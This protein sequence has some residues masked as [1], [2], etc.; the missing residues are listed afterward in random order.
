MKK[1]L[2]M[3]M[4]MALT[5][6]VLT[7]CGNTT[8]VQ[9]GGGEQAASE[10]EETAQAAETEAGNEAVS[11]DAVKTGISIVTTLEGENAAADTD[12][13]ATSNISVVAVTVGDDG[14]IDACAI[15]GIKATINFSKEGKLVDVKDSFLSKNELGKDYGMNTASSI[16]KEWNEQAEAL[17]QYA[18]GKTVEE[19]KNGA[20]DEAGMAKDADLAAS[21]TMYIG[22]FVDQIEAAANNA[23]HLGAAKG[24]R[25]VITQYTHASKSKDAAADADGLTQAYATIAAITLKDNTVSSMILDGVQA[26]V[27][28]DAA[29]AITSDLKAAVPTKNELGEDYGMKA[30]SGIGKEWNEQAAAFAAYVTG[31]TIDEV[32]GIAVTEEGGAADADLAASVTVSIGNFIS[33]VEKAAQ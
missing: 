17:A 32:S 6:G 31:K 20:V 3:L 14:V 8:V 15:D 30:A 18:V 24:D 26:N 23:A 13:Y 12:G 11:G 27:N 2:A 25:L 19:L 16:G 21:A 5:A 4:T 29:G 1:L 22:S 28:F 10:T 33:L 7:A 9:Q